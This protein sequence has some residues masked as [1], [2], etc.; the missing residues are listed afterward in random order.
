MIIDAWLGSGNEKIKRSVAKAVSWRLV[1]TLDTILISYVVTGRAGAAL[2]I[3]GMELFTK[4][5]LY[6]AHER[7][8]DRF[9]WGRVVNSKR[10]L[11]S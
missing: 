4:M 1:G 11:S 8:W 3:G 5:A 10:G 2:S 7:L 9:S 6:V